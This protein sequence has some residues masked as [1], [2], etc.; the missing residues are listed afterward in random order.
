M[1][2]ATIT[3]SY[4]ATFRL[5]SIPASVHAEIVEKQTNDYDNYTTKFC[6]V[7]YLANRIEKRDANI[8]HKIEQAEWLWLYE[9]ETRHPITAEN[10]SEA[11]KMARIMAKELGLK[12]I[13]VYYTPAKKEA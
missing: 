6:P 13:Y 12:F 4:E 10:K 11:T 9:Q 5:K 3:K 2:T 7:E 1:T 8:Q